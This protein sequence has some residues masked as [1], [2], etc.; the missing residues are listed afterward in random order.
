MS[1]IGD[2]SHGDFFIPSVEFSVAFYRFN[3]ESAIFLVVSEFRFTG[4]A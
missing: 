3:N 1:T 4:F 2:I